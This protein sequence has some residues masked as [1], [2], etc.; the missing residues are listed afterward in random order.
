MN[1]MRIL[2]KRQKPFFKQKN[3]GTEKY[4]NWTKKFNRGVWQL[5][6]PSKQAW[7]QFIWNYWVGGANKKR[8]EESQREPK[9]LSVHYQGDQ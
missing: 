7:R 3:S 6:W 1:K 4:N 8:N 2:T 5:P 9:G